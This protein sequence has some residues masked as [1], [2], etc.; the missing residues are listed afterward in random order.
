MCNAA[1]KTKFGTTLANVDFLHG[2]AESLLTITNL[3]IGTE[4]DHHACGVSLHVAVSVKCAYNERKNS[5]FTALHVNMCD[6]LA[7]LGFRRAIIQA[8][9]TESGAASTTGSSDT[10]ASTS[11]GSRNTTE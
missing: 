2:P 4:C 9:Q 8:E 5:M 3:L 10:D 11:S 1:A 6:A 7:V